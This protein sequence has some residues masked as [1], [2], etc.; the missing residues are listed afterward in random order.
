MAQSRQ[1]GNTDSKH[2]TQPEVGPGV[3]LLPLNTSGN[4]L[5]P[6]AQPRRNNMSAMDFGEQV[7]SEH[8]FTQ[9]Q[10]SEAFDK[11]ANPHDWKAEILV[12]LPSGSCSGD[13]LTLIKEA[14]VH[15][16]GTDPE[17]TLDTETMRYEI[18]SIGYRMGPC[19]DH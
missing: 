13:A 16:T 15:F 10:L 8:G 11:V 3:G 4:K 9:N 19:G 12:R 5:K 7:V 18:Y 14:I 1:V 17:V 6:K 2:F